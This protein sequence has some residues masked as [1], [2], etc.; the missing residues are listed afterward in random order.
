MHKLFSIRLEEL[1]RVRARATVRYSPFGQR[2]QDMQ[3]LRDF[4]IGHLGDSLF[5]NVTLMNGL[6]TD[7]LERRLIRILRAVGNPPN[8]L[9]APEARAALG[10]LQRPT[11]P[12]VDPVTPVSQVLWD[13]SM[14]YHNEVRP[15][16][17]AEAIAQRAR[18]LT[19]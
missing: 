11:R 14:L 4:V 1:D 2:A 12:G 17:V 19:G 7:T 13:A 16:P 10:T 8:A 5:E 15:V 18:T 6:G 3:R 9:A